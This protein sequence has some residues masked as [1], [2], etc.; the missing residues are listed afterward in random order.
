[1]YIYIYIGITSCFS[2]LPSRNNTSPAVIFYNT[3]K[4]RISNCSFLSNHPEELEPEVAHSTCFQPLGEDTDTF[5]LDNRTS[6]GGLTYYSEDVTTKLI[7]QDGLFVDNN[8]RPNLDV[9]LIRRSGSYGHG[10]AL[11]IRLLNNTN[12][13]VCIRDSKFLRNFAEAHAGAMA[14]TVA[15]SSTDNKI[16]VLRSVFRRNMCQ[17]E[18]CTGGAVGVYFFSGTLLNTILFVDCN[19]TNN[20]ARSSGAM[21]LSTSVS[22]SGESDILRLT[23]CQFKSNQAFYD[24]TALGVF[25]LTQTNQVGIPVELESW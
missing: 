20:E 13:T 11:S 19:F 8:A 2:F 24:G 3:P 1:M 5:F 16:V 12:S 15:K 10:G 14:V 4:A 23:N 22:A 17:I 25:S 9:D 7:I 6:G 18:N 21:V